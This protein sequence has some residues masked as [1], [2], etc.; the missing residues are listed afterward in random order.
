[1]ATLTVKYQVSEEVPSG[2]VIGKLSQELGWEE[3]RAQ[4]GAA[5]QVLQLPQALPIQVDP[6]DGRLSTG[7]RL[8]REQL[9]RQRD[10][11]LVSFDVPSFC[12]SWKSQKLGRK[13][14]Q[15]DE[16]K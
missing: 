13:K 8:D 9:C 14:P 2:T 15:R 4:A 7:R 11:C 6:E 3:R 16:Y 5:F 12:V 10:P 1:M